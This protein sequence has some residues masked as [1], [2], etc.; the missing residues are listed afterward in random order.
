MTC[1]PSETAFF[2]GENES[3]FWKNRV[4]VEFL[5]AI[6]LSVCF[7]YYFLKIVLILPPG[8]KIIKILINFFDVGEDRTTNLLFKNKKFCQEFTNIFF[9]KYPFGYRFLGQNYANYFF[10][11]QLS[12]V[13]YNF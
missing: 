13:W 3:R 10:K 5:F 8:D 1:T 9:F 4:K 7:L 11:L 6:S 2:V 12:R